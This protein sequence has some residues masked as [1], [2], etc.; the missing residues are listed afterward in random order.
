MANE[1]QKERETKGRG[2]VYSG[3]K[4]RQG[5]IVLRT[6]SRRLVFFGGLVGF[7]LLAVIFRL[8]VFI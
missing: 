6:P 2:P 7:V 4:V 3:E 5:E 1:R 8:F